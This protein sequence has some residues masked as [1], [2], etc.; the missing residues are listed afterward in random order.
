MNNQELLSIINDFKSYSS[1][2]LAATITKI[3]NEIYKNY[4]ETLKFYRGTFLMKMYSNDSFGFFDIPPPPELL[5]T[6]HSNPNSVLKQYPPMFV[7]SLTTKIQL[8]FKI[9]EAFAALVNRYFEND[10]FDFIFFSFS[11][12]PAIYS[13]FIGKEYCK[14]ASCFLI[15]LF[16]EN[17]YQISS[18]ILS[19]FFCSATLFYEHLWNNLSKELI[20]NNANTSF[21]ELTDELMRSLDQAI[22]LLSKYHKRVLKKFYKTYPEKTFRFILIQLLQEQFQKVIQS[23]TDF[24]DDDNNNE[25]LKFLTIFSKLNPNGKKALSLINMLLNDNVNSSVNPSINGDEWTHG[26]PFLICHKDI[27]ILCDIFLSDK[28][29][30]FT[31][32][33][34]ENKVSFSESIN[35]CSHF[36]YPSFTKKNKDII[37]IGLDLFSKYPPSIEFENDS[38]LEFLWSHIISDDNNMNISY[39][40]LNQNDKYKFIKNNEKIYHYFLIKLINYYEKNFSSFITSIKFKEHLHQTKNLNFSIQQDMDRYLHN[41]TYSFLCTEMKNNIK[42]GI[43]RRIKE[44]IFKLTSG[45]IVPMQTL[46]EITCTALDTISLS[47]SRKYNELNFIFIDLIN[48]W[49]VNKWPTIKNEP[50]FDKKIKYLTKTSTY[51]RSFKN[52]KLGMRLKLMLRIESMLK[53]IAGNDF[54]KCW[55]E[56]FYSTLFLALPGISD[57]LSSF[58]FFHHFLFN[59]PSFT[60]LID[61]QYIQSWSLFSYG[62]FSIIQED[63]VLNNTCSNYKLCQKL[64]VLD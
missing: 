49:V 58:L 16:N 62:I 11:T 14:A 53:T 45:M 50:H 31:F 37:S 64:F 48:N 52:A 9:P 32:Y 42:L 33:Y 25:F 40:I 4:N 54:R 23:S 36:L 55:I 29:K 56:L 20:N 10:L 46:F 24:I 61:R 15:G 6:I 17:N 60:T 38:A 13:E 57:I 44:T 30:K 18:C 63:P 43:P 22:I 47:V 12:F 27:R 41:F 19:V 8:A 2:P 7:Q 5:R 59:E 51:L 21:D 39:K 26:I 28:D 34:D 3:R 1:F 35:L